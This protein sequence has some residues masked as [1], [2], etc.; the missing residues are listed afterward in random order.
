MY[1]HY[2]FN[3]MQFVYINTIIFKRYNFNA[4]Q[5]FFRRE[6]IYDIFQNLKFFVNKYF[7][8]IYLLEK[9]TTYVSLTFI[10]DPKDQMMNK[11]ACS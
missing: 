9:Y 4:A 11:I 6:M 2:Y 3:F 8:H 7:I 10:D 1:R 5:N